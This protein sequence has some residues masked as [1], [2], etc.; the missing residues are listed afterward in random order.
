METYKN[1]YNEKEDRMMWELHEIKAKIASE[2]LTEKEINERGKKAL[3]HY[4][5]SPFKKYPSVEQ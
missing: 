2:N 5:M 3:S 1:D 4:K